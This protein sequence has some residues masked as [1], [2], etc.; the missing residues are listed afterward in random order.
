MQRQAEEDRL[1]REQFR[2]QGPARRP[3][4]HPRPDTSRA[5]PSQTTGTASGSSIRQTRS[6]QPPVLANGSSHALIPQALSR[7]YEQQGQQSRGYNQFYTPTQ[8]RS[9]QRS[10]ALASPHTPITRPHSTNTQL[11][12]AV[13]PSSSHTASPPRRDFQHD[14][15]GNS[16]TPGLPA[17]KPEYPGTESVQNAEI[18]RRQQ[19]TSE[20][21]Y[22][23]R[24]N[25]QR[26]NPERRTNPTVYNPQATSFTPSRSNPASGHGHPSWD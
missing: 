3:E 18:W 13:S 8:N 15:P 2:Q 9:P 22:E 10:S 19:G 17:Y 1:L 12:S 6:L 5:T 25:R 20:Q 26:N 4:S 16:V 21:S 14:F 24:R 23:P 11:S 7:L